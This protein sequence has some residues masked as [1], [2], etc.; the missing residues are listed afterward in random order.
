MSFIIKILLRIF[1][2]FLSILAADYLIRDISIQGELPLSMPVAWAALSLSVIHAVIRPVVKLISL[3]VTILTLG[4]FL[5]V[6]NGLMLMLADWIVPGFEIYGI[7]AAIKG[8]LVIS[9]TSWILEVILVP[10]KSD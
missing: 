4:L 2:N 6:I 3:P 7:W 5:F 9:V 1:I 10:K 8:A